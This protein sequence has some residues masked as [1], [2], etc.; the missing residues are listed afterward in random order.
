M[1]VMVTR[2]CVHYCS[3]YYKAVRVGGGDKR[4]HVLQETT[5]RG[6]CHCVCVYYL[7]I[8]VCLLLQYLLHYK[9]FFVTSRV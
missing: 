1:L 6:R 5:S 3:T 7:L 8:S 2:V 4:G 9:M